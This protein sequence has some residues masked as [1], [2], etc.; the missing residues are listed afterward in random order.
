MDVKELSLILKGT[1]DP[2]Q[3]TEAENKLTQVMFIRF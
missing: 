3:R 1:I 2:N